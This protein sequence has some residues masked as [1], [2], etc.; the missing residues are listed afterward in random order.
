[1]FKNKFYRIKLWSVFYQRQKDCTTMTSKH[2]FSRT[3]PFR[4]WIS[5]HRFLLRLSFKLS[6]WS[7]WRESGSHWPDI[8]DSHRRRRRF[9]CTPTFQTITSDP[10][11]KTGEDACG[12]GITGRWWDN[13]KMLQPC[14]IKLSLL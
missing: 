5:L 2:F 3:T 7:V 8:E 14:K 4:M 12:I 1:M 11:Q 10:D 6:T 9:T 13:I